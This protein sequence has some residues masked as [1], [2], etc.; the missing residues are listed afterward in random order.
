MLE[1]QGPAGSVLQV[2]AYCE[3]SL[4][5]NWNGILMETCKNDF[6]IIEFEVMGHLK[7][8]LETSE[9]DH[10]EGGRWNK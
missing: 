4:M 7:C 5:L 10:K 8:S 2:S 1:R 6:K 3:F 9:Q